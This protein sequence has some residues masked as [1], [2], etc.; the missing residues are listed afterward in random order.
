MSVGSGNESFT[1]TED[2][3]YDDSSSKLSDHREQH[4]GVSATDSSKQPSDT[5]SLNQSG[6]TQNDPFGQLIQACQVGDFRKANQLISSGEV[7]ASDTAP[8]GVTPLHWAA[9]NNRLNICRFLL[10]KGATVDAKGGDIQ[11]TPLHWAC[12]NGLVYIAHLLISR[13][14]DPLRT[15]A[16]GFNSL[17]L[18]VHSSNVLLVIYLLHLEIPVDPADAGER[19]PLHWAAYQGDA[20]SVDAL[21]NWGADTKPS[22]DKGFTAL[23]WAIV[24]GNKPTI[25]RL[26]EGGCD[27]FAMSVSGKTP[28]VMAEEM[29]TINMWQAALT[30]A[31]RDPRTGA[32]I[33]KRFS[34]KTAKLIMYFAPFVLLLVA[35]NLFASTPVYVS[36]PLVPISAVLTLKMLGR[37][38]LPSIVIGPHAIMQTPIFSG[39]FSG[40]AFWVI[41]QYIFKIAG[42]TFAKYP[43]A[44]LIFIIGFSIVTYAFF[45]SMFSDP[46]YILP[47]GNVAKQRAMIEGLIERGEYDSRHFC[48][49]TYVR[50]PLRARYD[51][52]SKHVVAKFDHYCP[53]VYNVVGVRN[54][55]IFVVF[56]LAL[57]IGI[58]MY[59]N[60]FFKYTNALEIP[61]SD[62][63]TGNRCSNAFFGVT[64]C[65]AFAV[66]Y[67]GSVLTVWSFFNCVWVHFLLF[68]Q[69]IQVARG[70]TTNEAANLH[71]FGYMGGD[72]FSSLPMDHSTAVSNAMANATAAADAHK[73][74][75]HKGGFRTALK[76][77]GI[78]QFIATAKDAAS[79]NLTNK[80]RNGYSYSRSRNPADLGAIRNCTDFWFPRGSYNPLRILPEGAASFS[81]NPVDYYRMWDF[82]TREN[83]EA[84]AAATSGSHNRRDDDLEEGLGDTPSDTLL[85]HNPSSDSMDETLDNS[86]AV[87][88][89]ALTTGSRDGSAYEMSNQS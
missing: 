14:A 51:R 29:K 22:D 63:T 8:D 13:G 46:G 24:R 31:G 6:P 44:N 52:M 21:L 33:P 79:I 45:T 53:W 78:D 76:L 80:N 27:V 7:S 49:S 18:A 88:T 66:D 5:N 23:H 62:G 25:K 3:L 84:N 72:D 37:F 17:H 40:T 55:R 59:I 19:T 2:T 4:S 1:Y 67:Y 56:V 83:S 77:L 71:K 12:R 64:F 35:F 41:V 82:P 54:H 57:A 38:V 68:V 89:A 69:L 73:K 15:D 74:H 85:R 20:L 28:R 36:L 48:I 9:I 75:S 60:L 34:L 86:D 43:L 70:I 11:G 61:S 16:Q 87:S 58:P 10:D 42:V 30:E 50:K 81:G 26:I 47:L 39:L 65:H 32:V